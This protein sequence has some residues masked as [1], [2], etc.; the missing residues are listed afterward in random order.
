METNPPLWSAADQ[1]E[2]LAELSAK[3]SDANKEAP[4]RR[5]V[6]SLGMLLG[7]VL[8]EQAGPELFATVERL[9]R[10]LIQH[11]EG[12]ANAQGDE[13]RLLQEA[14]A[15]VGALDL[16]TAYRVAKAFGTYFELTNLAETNHRKRRRRAGQLHRDQPPL[17]GSFRGTLLYLREEGFSAQ[18]VLSAL[19]EIE[20]VPVF[21]AHPTEI[22][23]RTTLLKRRR[24]ADQLL[25]IDELPLSD[26]DASEHEEILLSEITA[27]W[28]TDE[29]RL[30]KP[31]VSD[32]I[33]SGIRYFNLSLF[34]AIPKIYEEMSES[35]R[36]VYG[37][38]V[39]ILDIPAILRFGS[40]I[41]GDRDGNPL[42]TAEKTSEALALSRDAVLHHYIEQSRNLARRLSVSEHQV[43]AS[44]K[45][46]A[47]IE[48][49]ERLISV[50]PSEY[51]RTPAAE[52]YRRLLLLMAIRLR[53]ANE[54]ANSN[55][56]AYA[57]AE[58]FEL[59]L[60]TVRSSLSEH[61]GLRM[62]Q[63]M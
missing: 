50:R 34:E 57:S 13:A 1:A 63:R 16:E 6:R 49:Y 62:A 54:P 52:V 21:T 59:D 38:D 42:V 19:A 27:L 58:E 35:F 41:G 51:E 40:W 11:R 29:V 60:L 5:D 47:A 22:T 20:V 14:R 24:I 30:N 25:Q 39:G 46:R 15:A 32:E 2:R 33:R 61:G 45:I 17:P 28:Q 53:K 31:S 55:P 36:A 48:R 10:L 12:G 43:S 9:R 4:L 56:I 8:T 18:Q 37:T 44:P 23:R 3:T 7:R 26:A